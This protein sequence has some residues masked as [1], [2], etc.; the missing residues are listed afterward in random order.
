ML[1]TV[2]SNLSLITL[3]ITYWTQLC[4][5]R[6]WQSF[7]V[8]CTTICPS[9]S[10]C[11]VITISCLWLISSSTSQTACCPLGPGWP[12]SIFEK[13]ILI[14]WKELNKWGKIVSFLPINTFSHVCFLMVLSNFFENIFSWQIHI[15]LLL[16][17]HK[18]LLSILPN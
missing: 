9:I 1:F 14:L 8:S 11:W 15:N 2:L 17:R 18:R 4:V 3:S 5:T 13:K 12:V 6:A 10:W 7:Q 16:M